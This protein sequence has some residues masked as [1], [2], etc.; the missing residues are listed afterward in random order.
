MGKSLSVRARTRLVRP[1]GWMKA[2]GKVDKLEIYHLL[3]MLSGEGSKDWIENV[4]IS[5]SAVGP[6]GIF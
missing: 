2:S 5:S 1:A 4:E 6:G 3:V